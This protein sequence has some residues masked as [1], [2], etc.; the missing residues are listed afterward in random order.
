MSSHTYTEAGGK[1][2]VQRIELD[3]GQELITT[4][5]FTL[6]NPKAS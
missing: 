6:Q 3:D 5:S 2:V 4:S 1:T